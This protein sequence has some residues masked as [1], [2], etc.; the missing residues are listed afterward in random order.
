M[1]LTREATP[2]SNA[3]AG[4]QTTADHE[5]IN[6]SDAVDY[7]KKP[8]DEV[9]QTK[10][11]PPLKKIIHIK[12][13]HAHPF[14]SAEMIT[15][16]DIEE[17]ALSQFRVA[18]EIKKY[19][20]CPIVSE[21]CYYDRV[22][23]LCIYDTK[24][25][26]PDG[27]LDDFNKLTSSQ[28]RALH[29]LGGAK[30]L[31]DLGEIPGI[32]KSMHDAIANEHPA[33]LASLTTVYQKHV[34]LE[35]EYQRLSALSANAARELDKICASHG[36]KDAKTKKA[37]EK[38]LDFQ[39]ASSVAFHNY[40]E[41]VDQ[42]SYLDNH[43]DTQDFIFR[44]R[45]LD[46]IQCAIEAAKDATK[47]GPFWDE[48]KE[49]LQAPNHKDP[50]LI[51]AN[52]KMHE[53]AELALRMFRT[54][55]SFLPQPQDVI[56][57][58]GAAHDFKPYCDEHGFGLEEIDT[59]VPISKKK[60][61]V[62]Q[63][64]LIATG[65]PAGC[66]HFVN[67]GDYSAI[68]NQSKA[69]LL[70]WQKTVH[71]Q[72]REEAANLIEKLGR[73]SY[74]KESNR[75]KDVY[76]L[77]ALVDHAYEY[78]LRGHRDVTHYF[79]ER[80]LEGKV[81]KKTISTLPE[82]SPILEEHYQPNSASLSKICNV[83]KIAGRGMMVV[84]VTMDAVKLYQ[85]YEASRQ[86]GNYD[87]FFNEGTRIIGGWSGSIALGSVSA[88]L[89]ATTCA[90]LG[91][92]AS[93]V[94]GVVSGIAGSVLGYQAGEKLA[95]VIKQSAQMVDDLRNLEPNNQLTH[96]QQE[97]SL[98]Q[99]H[100]ESTLGN[101]DSRSD[102]VVEPPSPSTESLG[103]FQQ[104][105]SDAVKVLQSLEDTKSEQLKQPAEQ[106]IQPAA[107]IEPEIQV[108]AEHKSTS[109][110][111]LAHA[112]AE[113]IG[114]AC[115]GLHAV[116]QHAPGVLH[117]LGECAEVVTEILHDTSSQDSVENTVCGMVAGVAKVGVEACMVAG[118]TLVPEIEI[119]LIAG[120]GIHTAAAMEAT[121]MCTLGSAIQKAVN[122]VTKPVGS[123][124]SKV[125]HSTFDYFKGRQATSN[126]SNN[127][128]A[129]ALELRNQ[130]KQQQ[131]PRE[132]DA[133]S[134]SRNDHSVAVKHIR[135][136]VD[137]PYKPILMPLRIGARQ[138]SNIMATSSAQVNT[139]SQEQSMRSALATPQATTKVDIPYRP[140]QRPL[141][142]ETK[143]SVKTASPSQVSAKFEGP[144]MP[145]GNLLLDTITLSTALLPQSDLYF[146]ESPTEFFD[147]GIDRLSTV[148]LDS[149]PRFVSSAIMIPSGGLTAHSFP[150]LKVPKSSFFQP[151][152]LAM[153]ASSSTSRV[154]SAQSTLE[155]QAST[156]RNSDLQSS[157]Q[158]TMGGQSRPRLLIE[159]TPD[160]GGRAGFIQ[161]GLKH[162]T[163]PS[164]KT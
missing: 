104:V 125:C 138:S 9:T 93:V 147:H 65:N 132:H 64:A 152:S 100:V 50:L 86:S 126:H 139:I 14:A 26:F 153:Y 124:V 98:E 48:L 111:N 158:K 31:L 115:Q 128:E 45:E 154:T 15:A 83:I 148:S 120:T 156:L 101:N 84:G 35:N 150:G 90:P 102:Q 79:D 110:G 42:F 149:A 46:L 10:R 87:G 73:N 162:W 109:L 159:I 57:V 3:T 117:T 92:V 157:S 140:M 29:D 160:G 122:G 68:H 18:M 5:A 95:K 44:R 107:K 22:K 82:V 113:G 52:K 89:G 121:A 58:Y 77:Q 143:Q 25:I 34:L 88:K 66:S 55:Q 38:F 19:P 47:P 78:R 69:Q 91:P 33:R 17:I 141:R 133:E 16:A 142:I 32:Y 51:R 94:G 21:G 144:S 12:Q 130:S 49:I 2:Q 123:T 105:L 56:V 103:M 60:L 151:S 40:M 54:P 155:H 71:V 37:R 70:A 27:F 20:G 116:G 28:K 62:K 81:W 67:E 131:S 24:T 11:S 8:I 145:E 118:L 161:D 13:M 106:K 112:I 99:N 39:K 137:I 6:S 1:P 127:R 96:Q 74:V 72:L 76:F 85:A 53:I 43:P 136:N 134:I 4:S 75:M 30:I 135:S 164:M 23:P 119:P 36:L 63:T 61:V 80:Y 41:A 108:A 146:T 97:H 163:I 59:T 7:I 114:T 129:V